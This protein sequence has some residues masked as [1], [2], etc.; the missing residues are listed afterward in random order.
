MK[1]IILIA[2]GFEDS[3]FFYPYFRL[4]EEGWEVNVAGP[5]KGRVTGKH[6]YAFDVNTAF[7]D[8]KEADYDV[9]VLPGGKA[10][11]TVRLSPEAVAL[12][13]T[14]LED[15]RTVAAVCHGPQV[16]ISADVLRGRRATCYEAVRDDVKAAGAEYLDEEVVVDGNLITSRTP[17]DL[18]AFCRAIFAGIHQ[19]V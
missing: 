17:A 7:S 13:R 5:E 16:L 10:P 3:E 15:G 2:D 9:L 11:E 18:P 12:T 19:A 4:Q 1:A 8:I 14:M 6:G